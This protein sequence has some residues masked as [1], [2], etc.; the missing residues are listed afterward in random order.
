MKVTRS[1]LAVTLLISSTISASQDRRIVHRE[2]PEYPQIARRFDLYGTV[3]LKIRVG[4]DGAVR[5]AECIGGH[6]V[7]AEAALRAV[8]SWKYQPGPQESTI[9]VEV[10]F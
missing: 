2:E 1:I 3:K 8:K 9:L 7:L 5:R 6:P 10:R 4:P